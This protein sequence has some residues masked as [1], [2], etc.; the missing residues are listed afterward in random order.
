MNKSRVKLW[1]KDAEVN[2]K[3]ADKKGEFILVKNNNKIVAFGMMKPVKITLK[4]NKFIIQGIGRGMAIEKRKGWG[5]ILNAARIQKLKQTGKTG[6]AFTSRHNIP[7][8]ESAGYKIKKNGIK[9]FRYLNPKTK[10]L[11]YDPDGDMVYYEGKDQFVTKLLKSKDLA[12][13]NT[14]FW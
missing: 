1:G 10:E 11:V 7:F 8:F 14:D 2:F 5:K 6:I 12:I 4:K 9:K 13:T 3:E